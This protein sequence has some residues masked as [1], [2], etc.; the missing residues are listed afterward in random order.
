MVRWLS[1]APNVGYRWRQRLL[2]EIWECVL[3]QT[4]DERKNPLLAEYQYCHVD[5][6]VY[7]D[8]RQIYHS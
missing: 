2:Q 1:V 4:A 6:S 8:G 5:Q 3:N 7:Q